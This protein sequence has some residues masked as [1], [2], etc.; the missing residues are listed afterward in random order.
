MK[1]IFAALDPNNFFRLDIDNNTLL[2][3]EDAYDWLIN[4][5]YDGVLWLDTT[6]YH[7][8]L[9]CLMPCKLEI[10]KRHVNAVVTVWDDEYL[11]ESD[12][13][14]LELPKV[15]LTRRFRVMRADATKFLSPDDIELINT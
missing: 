13:S 6:V 14:I 2:Q 11:L 8:N 15:Y 7:F 10:G 4:C 1:T 12:D 9:G 3:I 5:P